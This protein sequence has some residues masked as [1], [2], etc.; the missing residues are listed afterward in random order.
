MLKK[1]PQIWDEKLQM[2]T[3]MD[4]RMRQMFWALLMLVG[5]DV[6]E[7]SL[8]EAFKKSPPPDN[9][10]LPEYIQ[11][12]MDEIKEEEKQQKRAELAAA[13]SKENFDKLKELLEL[14]RSTSVLVEAYDD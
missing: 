2:I 10:L 12:L 8:M 4:L 1:S 14:D 6:D 5:K 13:A 3:V 11:K 7:Q 9:L